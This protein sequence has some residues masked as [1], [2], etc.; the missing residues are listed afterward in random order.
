MRIA[1]PIKWTRSEK[2]TLKVGRYVFTYSYYTKTTRILLD[3]K[4]VDKLA[5]FKSCL[6][7]NSL[8]CLKAK[9]QA[10]AAFRII[11]GKTVGECLAPCASCA[12]LN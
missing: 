3:R 6:L 2:L 9:R 4:I 8:A 7:V 11:L 12:T 10:I 5:L 1:E